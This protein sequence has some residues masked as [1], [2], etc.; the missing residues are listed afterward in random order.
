MV[1]KQIILAFLDVLLITML[2]ITLNYVFFTAHKLLH[3]MLMIRQISVF[4]FVLLYLI[5][6]VKIW[7][8]VIESVF[9]NAH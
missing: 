7:M 9:L 3:F 8:M 6:L 2:M 1:M 4:K 5:I